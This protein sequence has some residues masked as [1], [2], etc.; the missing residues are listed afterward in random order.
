LRRLW[1]NLWDEKLLARLLIVLSV[2]MNHVVPL[3]LQL[4]AFGLEG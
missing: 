3:I 1:E 4:L 2:G